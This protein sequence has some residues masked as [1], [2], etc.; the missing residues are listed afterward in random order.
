[1]EQMNQATRV[2]IRTLHRELNEGDRMT[3]KQYVAMTGRLRSHPKG[4]RVIHN[5]NTAASLLIAVAYVGLLCMEFYFGMPQLPQT[6]L[7]PLSGFLTL[8]AVR[9]LI[10]RSRPYEAFHQSP[11]IPKKT[12]GKSFPSRHVFS[13][14]MIAFT[15]L[16]VGDI[17]ALAILLLVLATIL[18]V[19]RVITG[20]HYISDVLA[21][22]AWAVVFAFIGYIL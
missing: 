7:I 9:S 5:F 2:E 20:V 13:A 21:G 15:Y 11:V 16:Y 12:K 22:A 14:Y 19:I 1:M 3:E 18:A 10:N 4:V 8:S 17:L 6:V